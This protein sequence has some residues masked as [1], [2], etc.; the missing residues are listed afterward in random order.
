MKYSLIITAE[1]DYEFPSVSS[2]DPFL[3]FSIGEFIDAKFL[4]GHPVIACDRY[5]IV[6]VMHYIANDG[7]TLISHSVH[8][9]VEAV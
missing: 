8:L 6:E 9:R 2:T 7:A 5:K 4:P 3:K 1:D